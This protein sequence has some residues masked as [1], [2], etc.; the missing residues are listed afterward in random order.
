MINFETAKVKDFYWLLNK[1][2]NNGPH[3]GPTK[4][5]KSMPICAKPWEKYFISI[6]QVSRE[7]MLREF[8]FKFL[9][10]IVVTK[11]ELCRFGIK[12]DSECLYCGEQDSIEHTFLDCSFTKHFLSKLVQWFNSCNQCSFKPTNQELLFGIFSNPANKELLK[13]LTTPCFMLAIS[14]IQI[15]YTIILF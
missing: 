12:D 4:W 9:H 1:Q 15:S 8:Q 7:N 5:S 3:T 14:S 10:R 6:K 2:V 11:K 13:K